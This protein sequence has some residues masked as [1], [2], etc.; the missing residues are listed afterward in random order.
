MFS[1]IVYDSTILRGHLYSTEAD[2]MDPSF[3]IDLKEDLPFDDLD[4]VGFVT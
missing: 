4:E 3:A 1:P 2:G